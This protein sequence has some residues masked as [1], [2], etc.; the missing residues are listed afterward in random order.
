M[1]STPIVEEAAPPGAA[2]YLL[3]WLALALLTGLT[4]GLSTVALGR[5]S[6]PLALVIAVTKAAIVALFFM[7]LWD[8]RGASR[9]VLVTAVLFVVVLASLV[10]ADVLTRFPPALPAQPVSLIALPTVARSPV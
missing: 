10:V 3:C 9:L 1:S 5:W 2:R 8:Q 6:L 4:F 7:H